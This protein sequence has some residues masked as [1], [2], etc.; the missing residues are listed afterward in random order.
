MCQVFC[1]PTTHSTSEAV[2][3]RAAPKIL[4][5]RM[6]ASSQ[7][8]LPSRF[9]DKRVEVHCAPLLLALHFFF[10]L[11]ALDILLIVGILHL[12]TLPDDSSVI[13]FAWFAPL[14]N[15]ALEEVSSARSAFIA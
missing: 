12:P 8:D 1:A 2:A 7:N 11:F 14:Y 5:N 3:G 6:A 15:F 9:L 13:S 4:A 10:W